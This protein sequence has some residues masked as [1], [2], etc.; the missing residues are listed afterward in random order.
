MR[1]YA[2]EC[3]I[4]SNGTLVLFIENVT[5]SFLSLFKVNFRLYNS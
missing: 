1:M 3:I 4:S 5:N 2:Q